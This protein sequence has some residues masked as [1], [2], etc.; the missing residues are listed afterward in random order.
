ML[1]YYTSG[2]SHG[3]GLL[4]IIEGIPAGLEITTADI[5]SQLERRQKGYGRGGRMKIEKDRIE[6]FTGVRNGKTIGSP[7][8]LILVNRDWENWKDVMSPEHMDPSPNPVEIPRPG[9][10]DYAGVLKYRH[11][12]IRNVLERSSARETA[13]RAALAAVCRKLLLQF[14]I[15]IA[16]HVI[17]IRDVVSSVTLNNLPCTLEKLNDIADVSPVRCLDKEAE[18]RMMQVI[19]NAKE[20]GDSV[21]GI[22]EIIAVG[23]P[24]GLGSYIQ[25]DKRLDGLIAYA[26]MSIPAVKSVEIGMGKDMSGKSGSEVHDAIYIKEDAVPDDPLPFYRKTNN[27]GGIEGGITNAEPVIV[28]IG[29]KPL[30]TLATPLDSVNLFKRTP[31]S[32]HKERTDTCAVQP[33]SVIGE[34]MLALVLTQVFLEKFGGDSIDEIK[35]HYSYTP[36]F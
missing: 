21:G 8:G 17:Q 27:A 19:N 6:I 4:G 26:M 36:R 15:H 30:P 16:S 34:A 3:K 35:E 9:H 24:P 22:I 18:T 31:E 20:K 33:C 2:E 12:D 5:D 23:V 10:A 13:M 7:I 14:H 29:M 32:A 11:S 25:W 1:R 28:R